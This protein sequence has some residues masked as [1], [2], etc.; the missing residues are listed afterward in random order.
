MR[1][2]FLD[3]GNFSDDINKDI[4]IAVSPNPTA[5]DLTLNLSIEEATDMEVSIIDL[6]GRVIS[7]RSLS[8]VTE[9][10]EEF[11]VS[12]LANGVYMIHI[13]TKNGVQTQKF[14]VSK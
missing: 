12:I 3:I 6:A 13:S 11:N 14:V 2:W 10:K 1:K 9:L 7:S 8:G 4:K 5:S